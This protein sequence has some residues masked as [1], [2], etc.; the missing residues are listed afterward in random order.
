[1]GGGAGDTGGPGGASGGA[2]VC[3][4][5]APG[6]AA[7][8]SAQMA[9]AICDAD[10]TLSLCG[11]G[12]QNQLS[13]EACD[14]SGPT[15]SCFQCSDAQV[16]CPDGCE[17]QVYRGRAYAFCS[18]ALDFEDAEAVCELEGGFLTDLTDP[19]ED[20]FVMSTL[21][22]AGLAEVWFGA[23][24]REENG[25]WRWP[26]GTLFYTGTANGAAVDQRYINWKSGEPSDGSGF[27][28]C[29]LLDAAYGRWMDRECSSLRPFVCELDPSPPGCGDGDRK[30]T[31]VCDTQADSETCD[32]DCTTPACGDGYP[33]LDADEECDDGNQD[34]LDGCDSACRS[35]GLVGHYPLSETVGVTA[36]D[37]S[38]ALAHLSVVGT[39]IVLDAI[40]TGAQFADAHYAQVTD[41]DLA[42]SDEVS[43]AF[44][45]R[46]SSS[47]GIRTILESV[48]TPDDVSLAVR[49]NGANLVLTVVSSDGTA[50]GL[51][52]SIPYD[53]VADPV[54]LTHF[55]F[56]CSSGTWSAYS[57][58]ELTATVDTSDCLPGPLSS[59]W[60]VGANEGGDA[61]YLGGRLADLRI[62]RRA[63]EPGEIAQLAELSP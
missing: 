59:S 5:D 20:A 51:P 28:N 21:F 6:F 39:G 12:T 24:D 42:L 58:G 8:C 25:S 23:S 53:G 54:E 52:F 41:G 60:V 15:T 37:C 18:E 11:D 34:E 3:T 7:E 56:T 10:C 44:F 9:S 46:T 48:A 17:C 35:T 31:E 32:G 30:G 13:K 43:I 27:Q 40:Q 50:D 63:L 2:P 36:F 38:P 62:Y 61:E 22:D 1:M 14:T 26:D 16:P 4:E 19:S 33:N 45:V 57:E 49:V 29:G 47:S 55:A